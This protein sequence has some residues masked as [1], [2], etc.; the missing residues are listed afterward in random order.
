MGTSD[1]STGLAI[2]LLQEYAEEANVTDAELAAAAVEM[3]LPPEAVEQG[4]PHVGFIVKFAS[5]VERILPTK[6]K[7][8]AGLFLRQAATYINDKAL[9]ATIDKKVASLIFGAKSDPVIVVAHSLGT[10]SAIAFFPIRSLADA[11]CHCS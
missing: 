3:G 5:V 1:I 4:V 7:V 11:M 10:V 9:A 2:G 6:G 8:M